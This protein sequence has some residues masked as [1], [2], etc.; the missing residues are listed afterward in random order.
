MGYAFMSTDKVKTI[1]HLEGKMKHNYREIEVPNANPS[2]WYKNSEI[3]NNGQ[4][5][6]VE[7]YR[8]KIAAS[9]YYKSHAV[10]KDAVKAIEVMMTCSKK[11]A[12]NIDLDLWK[13]ANEAWLKKTFGED[14]VISLVYHGDE[15]TPHIH[16]IVVPMIDGVLK[17][18]EFLGSPQKLAQMQDSYA[19]AMSPFGLERGLRNSKAKHKDIKKYHA[20]I[21]REALRALPSVKIE[22]GEMESAEDYRERANEVYQAANLG[23]LGKLHK[24]QRK[25]E[26]ALTN[27]ANTRVDAATTI[28]NLTKEYQKKIEGLEE[29]YAEK[30]GRYRQISDQYG[31]PED[32]E[33][34]LSF[35]RNL[36]T[37]QVEYYK[38]HPE[39]EQR[40][41]DMESS[42]R[43]VVRWKEDKERKKKELQR[44]NNE[45]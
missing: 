3:I 21:D 11:D 43:E 44:P 41:R 15:A 1:T 45:L 36:E 13:K 27:A 25:L 18:Y 24:M 20:E 7:A 10:R 34:Q 9:D 6:Y 33:K 19:E 22:N 5:D 30:L 23:N 2:D 29:D 38:E 39:K 14:N 32:I 4:V 40:L 16:G 17:C 8:A 35:L 37:G 28:E 31:N 12:D 26:E 42:I